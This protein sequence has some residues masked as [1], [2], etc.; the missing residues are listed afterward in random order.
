MAHR[1]AFESPLVRAEAVSA[2]AVPD[3]AAACRVR[4]T[5]DTLIDGQVHLRGVPTEAELLARLL[6]R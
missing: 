2:V 3:L 5:P 1:F 4:S 6:E